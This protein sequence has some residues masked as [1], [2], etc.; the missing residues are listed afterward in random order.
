MTPDGDD[1]ALKNQRNQFDQK[2]EDQ[3]YAKSKLWDLKS[4]K[5][6]SIINNDGYVVIFHLCCPCCHSQ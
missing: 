6:K 1:N 3:G 4:I 2:N 5:T